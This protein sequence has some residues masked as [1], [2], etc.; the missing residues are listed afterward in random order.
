VCGKPRCAASAADWIKLA[1]F[2]R[3]KFEKLFYLE[4]SMRQ[5]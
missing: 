3:K 2:R 1:G 4:K 5:W